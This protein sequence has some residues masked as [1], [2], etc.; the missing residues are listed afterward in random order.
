MGS[1]S[2]EKVT[3]THSSATHSKHGKTSTRSVEKHSSG[4]QRIQ[5]QGHTVALN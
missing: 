4:A 5:P 1:S 2:N 3:K